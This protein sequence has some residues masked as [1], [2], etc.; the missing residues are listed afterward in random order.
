MCGNRYQLQRFRATAN[1]Q[2]ILLGGK[3]YSLIAT[4]EHFN[5]LKSLLGHGGLC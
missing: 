1:A 4:V 5:A 3:L 2:D